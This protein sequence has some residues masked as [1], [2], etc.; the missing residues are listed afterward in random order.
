MLQRKKQVMKKPKSVVIVGAG[1]HAKVIADIIIKSG[2]TIKGFLDDNTAKHS[3]V[4]GYHVLGNIES[5]RDFDNS[6]CFVLGIGD[7]YIRQSMAEQFDVKWHTAIH[8]SAVIADDVQIKEGSVV[9][10]S[11]VINASAKIGRHCIVN[12]ASVV[13][14]DSF[15]EDFVHISPNVSLGGTVKVGEFTHIGIGST[16][17]NNI[18]IASECTIGAGAVVVSDITEKGV[19]VGVPAKRNS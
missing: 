12:S 14:H 19:Y 8:P 9:M 3:L 5:I 1:G 6:V 15:I 11:C 4:L 16:V 10:A 17:I 13:E 2:D 18:A 7:N